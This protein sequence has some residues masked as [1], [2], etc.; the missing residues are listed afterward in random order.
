MLLWMIVDEVC[1]SVGALSACSP[2]SMQMLVIFRNG[3]IW[4]EAKQQ[5]LGQEH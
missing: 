4:G 1:A 5:A 3:M 2:L